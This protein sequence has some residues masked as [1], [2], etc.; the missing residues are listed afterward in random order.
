MS[1]PTLYRTD[2]QLDA[3]LDTIHEAACRFVEKSFAE[4]GCAPFMFVIDDGMHWMWIECPWATPDERHETMTLVR[5]WVTISST[6]AYVGIAEAFLHRTD[7]ERVRV[8]TDNVAIVHSHDR[9][10]KARVTRWLV[11]ERDQPDLNFLGPRIEDNAFSDAGWDADMF[12]MFEHDQQQA[13][14][15]L[16]PRGNDNGHRT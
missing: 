15:A 14:L 11:T 13:E 12:H 10:G 8:V 3:T 4:H 9:D 2:I 5:S 6:H 16:H 7:A 1:L